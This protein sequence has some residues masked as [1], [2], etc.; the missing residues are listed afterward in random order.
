V[1][2][3]RFRFNG[4]KK[5]DDGVPIVLTAST[6][7]MS[8]FN[9]NPFVAFSGGFPLGIVP[10]FVL[11]KTL[12]PP[13]PEN[14]DKTAKFA[15]YGLR[16]VEA[17]LIEEFGEENVVTVHPFHLDKFVGSQTRI[18]GI[19]TMDP[20]GL[21]FVSR[22]YT[23]IL[24]LHGKPATL[25]E[26]EAL[27]S[28]RTLKK[29]RPKILVGGA[30]AWQLLN[31]ELR[32][33]LGIDTIILGQAERSVVNVIRKAMNGEQL[34]EVIEM[35]APEMSE[36]P[37]IRNPS[38]YG[39]VEI[40][41]GCGRGCHFCSPT[42]RKAYSFPLE[43]ILKEVKLNAH[44]GS[45]M[46][47]VQTDDLFLYKS[48]SGFIP[49]SQ[50]IIELI[51]RINRIKGV[52]FI[53]IAHVSLPPVVYDPEIVKEIGPI[54]VEKSIWKYGNGKH[55]ASVEI[56]IET[57]S[58]R[59]IREHMKGKPLPYKPEQWQDVVVQA[60]GILNDS[61]IYPLATLILGLP[62]EK[63][64]DVLE[65]IELLDKLKN[66]KIF[67]VPLFFVSEEGTTLARLEHMDIRGLS[68]L[69]WEILSTC[70]RHNVERW[71]PA[72]APLIKIA[73]VMPYRARTRTQL[74]VFALATMKKKGNGA[75]AFFSFGTQLRYSS[76][77]ERFGDRQNLGKKVAK[78]ARKKSTKF[79]LG[80]KRGFK[81]V[82]GRSWA[83]A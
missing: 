38:I 6:I 36:I 73:N 48:R 71:G 31:P 39:A 41:R 22:T 12:Y 7:E 61:G 34:D 8:D 51:K 43:H 47:L 5:G 56:G 35:E 16:K 83:I 42:M 67:Y 69:H 82:S 60:A 45:R 57:G 2:P 54:L 59:L 9:L 55:C 32:T 27:L 70:W 76:H 52:E 79:S 20:L 1:R 80:K 81:G 33:D 72:F 13:V 19:S 74:S 21:G 44:N 64:E 4:K 11:R 3:I 37:T 15:P 63:E 14:M 62:G 23:S 18:V 75:K 29:N 77:R 46:I 25:M 68:D 50:A 53:Q 40:T 49:N 58:T 26:F 28:N 10:K 30:G 78:I 24:G 66:D 65:T 17:L